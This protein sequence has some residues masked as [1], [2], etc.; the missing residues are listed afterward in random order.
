MYPQFLIESPII[1][2][3]LVTQLIQYPIIRLQRLN[4]LYALPANLYIILN[5]KFSI[6]IKY[7]VYTCLFNYF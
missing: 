3:K 6:K 4:L 5:Q 7:K 1:H 2:F